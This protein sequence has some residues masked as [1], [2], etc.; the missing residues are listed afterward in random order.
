VLLPIVAGEIINLAKRLPEYWENLRDNLVTW[1]KL[2]EDRLGAKTVAQLRESLG[3]SGEKL[4]GWTTSLVGGVLSGGAA[5]IN[6]ASLVFITPVVA[7]FL[8]RDWDRIVALIDGW[9]P[10]DHAETIRELARQVDVTLAGFVRGQALVCIILGTFYAI[11][12]AVVGLD[13]GTLIGIGAGLVSFVPYVGAIVGFVAAVGLALVQ[14]DAWG[15][16]VATGAVFMIGQAIEGNF[17]TPKLVGERVGLHPVWVIFGLLAGGTLFGF[18]GVLLSVPVAA[19]IGVGTR[20][21][22]RR[23]KDS[24]YYWGSGGP[25]Q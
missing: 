8:L 16:I 10:R 17:L 5:L 20:F 18:V 23:Y 3:G 7:F 24:S 4:V 21:A 6:L 13:F 11:G 22:I 25:E 1:G 14:F 15:P 2:I 19:V 12:L 9:L